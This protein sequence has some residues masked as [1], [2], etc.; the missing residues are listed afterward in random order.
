MAAE[1]GYPPAQYDLGNC[2]LN[3]LG[4]QKSQAEAVEWIRKA[5]VQGHEK[6][7]DYMREQGL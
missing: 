5:A 6:A 4:V 7:Q 2:Y 1:Q 3:G